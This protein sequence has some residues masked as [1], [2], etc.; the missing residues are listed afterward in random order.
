MQDFLTVDRAAR[1]L[2]RVVPRTVSSLRITSTIRTLP[3]TRT[4]RDRLLV[5]MD[6]TMEPDM[7]LNI[8]ITVGKVRDTGVALEA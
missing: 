8:A 4:L 6:S 2:L 1:S 5:A 3:I 7:A